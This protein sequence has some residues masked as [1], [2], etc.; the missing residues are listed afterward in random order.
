AIRSRS[1]DGRV[2]DD[3]ESS[4]RRRDRQLALGIFPESLAD[5]GALRAHPL[6][7]GVPTGDAPVQ[8]REGIRG[9]RVF[10]AGGVRRRL[11]LD[12]LFGDP[13]VTRPAGAALLQDE[14]VAGPAPGPD[15]R[16]DGVAAPCADGG[17]PAVPATHVGLG[18]LQRADGGAPVDPRGPVLPGLSCTVGSR[19]GDLLRG[20]RY[21]LALIRDVTQQLLIDWY[22]FEST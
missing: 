21:D 2:R 15:R 3:P 13:R 19:P 1:P 6:P 8:G 20:W 22:C 5:R 7:S 12:E 18:R 11:R 4:R 17:V 16:T 10:P 14:R 9:R